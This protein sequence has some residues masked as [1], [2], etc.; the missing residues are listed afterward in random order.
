MDEDLREISSVSCSE[1][2]WKPGKNFL[3]KEVKKAV[4][5]KKTGKKKGA[6]T[7]TVVVMEKQA[8][9]F[10]FFAVPKINDAENDDEDEGKQ[11]GDDMYSL[12][13]AND[14]DIAHTIRSSLIPEAV[15]WYTGEREEEDDY[16]YE[17]AI[18]L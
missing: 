4:K 5:A 8:S 9:F 12:D 1:I 3:V 17:Y 7:R 13:L 10:H 18:T 14:Y 16:E 6:D 11:N 15:L 2:H